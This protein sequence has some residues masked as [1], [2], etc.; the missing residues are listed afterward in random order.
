MGGIPLRYLGLGG[1]VL[2]AAGV[3]AHGV[4]RPHSVRGQVSALLF[5]AGTEVAPVVGLAL[6]DEP[7]AFVQ[8]LAPA[9]P[10]PPDAIRLERFQGLFASVDGARHVQAEI[11]DGRTLARLPSGSQVALDGAY[12][13]VPDSSGDVV[14]AVSETPGKGGE[15]ALLVL[16]REGSVVTTLETPEPLWVAVA[17][18]GTRIAIGSASGVRLVA[19]DG[20]PVASFPGAS[21]IGALSDGGGWLAFESETEAENRLWIVPADGAEREPWSL[22]VPRGKALLFDARGSRLVHVQGETLRVFALE[23]AWRLA[24]QRAA[25]AGSRWRDA[26]FDARGRLVAGRIRIDE[27]LQEVEEPGGKRELRGAAGIG[28]ELLDLTAG[29]GE[30]LARTEW[31]VPRWSGSSPELVVAGERIFALVWPSAFEVKP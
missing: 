11:H 5:R 13:F 1:G 28:V 6:E 17:R 27:P 16:D 22:A 21:E 8:V 26:A 25:P 9:A 20:E 24:L 4:W 19:R 10:A 2:L 30:V 29:P 3:L 31:T 23:E 14:V 12:E 15:H 18:L 7:R